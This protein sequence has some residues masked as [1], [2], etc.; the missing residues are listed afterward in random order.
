MRI[1]EWASDFLGIEDNWTP[2]QFDDAVYYF[3]SWFENQLAEGKSA[4]TLLSNKTSEEITED[5][6]KRNIDMLLGNALI[7]GV[8]F[9]KSI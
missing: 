1:K 6:N 3:G 5:D 4:K 8:D 7:G 2:I 9:H